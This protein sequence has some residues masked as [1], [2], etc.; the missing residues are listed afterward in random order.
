MDNYVEQYKEKLGNIPSSYTLNPPEKMVQYPAH[1]M[2]LKASVNDDNIAIVKSLK[3]QVGTS[4]EWYQSFVRL[5]HGDLGTQERHDATTESRAIESTPQEQ[6]QF[7]VTIPGCFHIWMA[8][9]DA[10]W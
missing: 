1:A 9:V 7:L 3:W 10:I 6:L 5:C 4:P 2:H 8:C